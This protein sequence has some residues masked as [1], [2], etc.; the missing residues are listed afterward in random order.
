VKYDQVGRGLLATLE[1]GNPEGTAQEILSTRQPGLYWLQHKIQTA[2]TLAGF[3]KGDH[4]LEVGCT[5]GSYTMFLAREGYE[6]TGLDISPASIAAAR[7]AAQNLGLSTAHFM[8][9]DVDNMKDIP[10]EAFDGAFS[11]S[12]LRY[13]PDP[14]RSL[15]EIRRVVRPGARVVVDFPNKYCPWFEAL[16]F[17]VGGERHI[18]DHTYSTRQV[19]EMMKAAGFVNIQAKR[20][21]FFAKLFPGQFVSLYKAVDWIAERTPLLNQFAGIIMCK[22]ENPAR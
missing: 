21:I 18:H 3:G 8:A 15:R 2:F 12:T 19:T 22:G 5:A 11:F 7:V 20:I 17:L 16:K 10:G 13:L 9:G 6:V 1:P 4:L 14:V